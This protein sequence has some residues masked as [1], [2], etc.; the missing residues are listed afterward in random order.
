MTFQQF[1]LLV[2][3]N[4]TVWDPICQFRKLMLEYTVHL[5]QAVLILERRLKLPEIKLYQKYHN[6]QLP[7]LACSKQLHLLF[8]SEPHPFLYNFDYVNEINTNCSGNKLILVNGEELSLESLIMST[9]YYLRP[10]TSVYRLVFNT[11]SISRILT[12]QCDDIDRKSVV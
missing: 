6:N 2:S 7:K 10:S 4:K 3:K 5:D 1:I 11:D 12:S 9:L 8:S